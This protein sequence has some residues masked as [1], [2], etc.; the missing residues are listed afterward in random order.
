MPLSNNLFFYERVLVTYCFI[1]KISI[2]TEYIILN[3]F[4]ILKTNGPYDCKSRHCALGDCNTIGNHPEHSDGV[5]LVYNLSVIHKT[6]G[7][8]SNSVRR[9]SWILISSLLI[10][11]PCSTDAV[12]EFERKYGIEIFPFLIE[13]Y[14]SFSFNLL[15]K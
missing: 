2:S 6:K 12:Q 5:I 9:Y 3:F 7:K 15:S 10:L 1:S 14:G 13:K 4:L 11:M 8:P